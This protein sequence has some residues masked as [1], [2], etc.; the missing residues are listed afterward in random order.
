MGQ[1]LDYLGA[2]ALFG[3]LGQDVAADL[4]VEQ[5]QFAVHR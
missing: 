1:A 4:P 2:P 5:H 3:L